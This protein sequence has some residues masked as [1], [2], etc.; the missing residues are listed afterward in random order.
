MAK[1]P[2]SFRKEGPASLANQAGVIPQHYGRG[3][4]PHYPGSAIRH[5]KVFR[6]NDLY[7]LSKPAIR[8]LARRG[9]CKRI[10]GNLYEEVRT[11]LKIW[12]S[13]VLRSAITYTEHARRKTI[14]A[15]DIVLGVKHFGGKGSILYI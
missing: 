10:N 6:D 1:S 2:K 11:V 12:L 15:M 9:G 4:G 7:A 8:R 3:K 5:V 13:A 14:T